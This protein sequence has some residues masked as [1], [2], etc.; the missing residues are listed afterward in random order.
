MPPSILSPSATI[1]PEPLS[2]SDFSPFGTVIECPLPPNQNTISTPFPPSQ[3]STVANQ[4]TAIKYLD[5]THMKNL[6]SNSTSGFPEKAVMNMFS[7]FPRNLRPSLVPKKHSFDVKIL[8][9]HPYTTQT[10]I[11]IG[12]QSSTLSSRYLV[13]VAPTLPPTSGSHFKTAGSP[14]L[15]KLRA[16]WADGRQAVT[17]SAGTWHAPMVV[18]GEQRVDFVVTQFA[19]G[20]ADEDCQEVVLEADS[21][22]GGVSVAI[23]MPEVTVARL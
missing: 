20:V 17:Y 5:V 1:F 23:E 14:D 12:L 2:Q 3:K 22:R 7:C 4:G 16:F 13:I 10:F 8:E 15:K 18:V 9:R 21:I 6:Y 11:P 19:N